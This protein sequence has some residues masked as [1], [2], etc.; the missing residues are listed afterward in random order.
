MSRPIHSVNHLKSRYN[1]FQILAIL[2]TIVTI[3]AVILSS[4]SS[5]QLGKLSR[6]ERK[7]NAT[8]TDSI[9]SALKNELEA[10]TKEMLELSEKLEKS[11]NA[12]QSLEKKNASLQKKLQEAH[13]PPTSRLKEA[14]NKLE[15]AKLNEPSEKNTQVPAPEPTEREASQTTAPDQTSPPSQPTEQVVSP[16]PSPMTTEN[17]QVE[18]NATQVE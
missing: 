7:T 4:I 6:L 1:K 10:A 15:P 9:H 14:D 18:N 11:S 12:N 5:F 3:I 13:Q 2:C 16:D 8:K 17:V